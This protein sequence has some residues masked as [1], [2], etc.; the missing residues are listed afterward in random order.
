MYRRDAIEEEEEVEANK[1]QEEVKWKRTI[2][3]N[4]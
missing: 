4:Q 3:L 2:E 1:I